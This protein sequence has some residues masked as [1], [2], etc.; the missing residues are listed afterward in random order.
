[1]REGKIISAA[2]AADMANPQFDASG[3]RILIVRLSPFRDI[4]VSYSHLVLFDEA[5]RALP[6]AFIDFAF[7]PLAPDRKELSEQGRPWFYGRASG[8]APSE[9]NLILISCAFTL[10]LVNVPWLAAQSGIPFSRAER[11]K[12]PGTP[13]LILGG[14]S[15]VTS[16]ALL[17][18]EGDR[19]VDSLVDG[20]FFGEGE[21]SISELVQIAAEGA[22]RSASQRAI[23]DAIAAR[24]AGFWPCETDR[25][26]Q[27]SLA[28]KRPSLLLSPLAL[29]GEHADHTKLAITAGCVGHCAFCLEGWDRRPFREQ[30]L[31]DI[32]SSARALKKSTGATD[33][34]L[35]SYNFN[36]HHSV[37]SIIP[38]LGRSFMRVSL[39]SQRLD[40]LARSP[41]LLNAEIAA[42]KRSF[43]LGIEGISDRMRR[44]FRKGIT[45]DE[46]QKSA[47]DIIAR[48]A[49]ELKLFY[50][51][52]G[53]EEETD[54]AE[55]GQYVVSLSAMKGDSR[56]HTRIIVSAGYLV[57]LPFTP[58]QF[59]P[60]AAN[61]DQLASISRRLEEMCAGAGMEYRLAA[62][63]ED[64]WADQ[65]LS[66][67]GSAAHGWLLD[68]PDRGRAYDT[69]LPRGSSASLEAHLR[70][71][72]AFSELLDEKAPGYRPQFAFIEREEHWRLL[73]SHYEKSRAFFDI[74]LVG[75]GGA[76]ADGMLATRNPA[77]SPLAPR[78]PLTIKTSDKSSLRA[79]SVIH[80]QEAAKARFE[81]VL[82]RV[83]EREMMAFSTPE[84]ECAWLMRS[85]SALV[86]NAERVL[87]ECR[88]ELPDDRWAD[89]LAARFGQPHPQL[90]LC[91]EKHFSLYGPDRATIERVI[92]RA[93]SALQSLDLNH[94]GPIS[95]EFQG[96]IAGLGGI[97]CAERHLKAEC[98]TLKYTSS[99][100]SE[101]A[102]A[103]ITA[104]WLKESG[105]HFTL[106]N[107]ANRHD[108]AISAD[109]KRK[110]SVQSIHIQ[111]SSSGV[112]LGMRLGYKA[113]LGKLSE[114]LSN[115]V[116]NA[117]PVFT[118]E[119]WD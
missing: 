102:L 20:I 51:I 119:G 15:A 107:A 43:T 101:D 84:Y 87:F 13:L 85:L 47:S 30:A 32:E 12:R 54:F 110:K 23:L 63:F 40:V 75:A 17:C 53:F 92:A 59:A 50:I 36:M 5:R 46:V 78:A 88:L 49:R 28:A 82:V 93:A 95:S 66:I 52:S 35:F 73:R 56:A 72:C 39:M 81:P 34:E 69:R 31:A 14:S 38:A 79:I 2:V 111:T 61:K 90:G 57:R 6:G 80:A 44:Y 29:N 108:F 83:V 117:E 60:L 97:E 11:R 74:G 67:A 8:R 7:L 76:R 26:A 70:G 62:T 41:T 55:F 64:Y 98:C 33:I 9:F 45:R 118:I 104:F 3:Y 113:D 16:G 109:S 89:T 112:S 65:L 114:A 96:S 103:R 99:T 86:P 42:G 100:L 116:P 91:G 1:M 22:A 37:E 10:E 58:L 68:C 115:A 71:S 25:F 48:G 105:L 27:R 4:E 94:S 19:I 24:V 77:A 18:T 21:G 106:N